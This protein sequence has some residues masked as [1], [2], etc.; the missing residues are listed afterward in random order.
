LLTF[1]EFQQVVK[2]DGGSGQWISAARNRRQK[3]LIKGSDGK[4]AFKIGK[5]EFTE[6]IFGLTAPIREPADV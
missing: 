6:K 2:S 1:E 3:Y 5:D 4:L